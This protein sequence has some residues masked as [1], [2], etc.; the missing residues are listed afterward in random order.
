MSNKDNGGPAFPVTMP[1]GEAYKGHAEFDGMTLRDYFAA[2]AM[3]AC[4][5]STK[6]MFGVGY[7]D[8]NANMAMA[9]YSI[10]DAML[11]ARKQ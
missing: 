10:A 5:S 7:K 6:G 11:E 4:L 3:Q 1:A 2:K 9:S 8:N